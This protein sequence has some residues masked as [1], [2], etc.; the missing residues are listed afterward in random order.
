MLAVE[1]HVPSR[2]RARLVARPRTG[3][4]AAEHPL[5]DAPKETER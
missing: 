5:T 3:S 1:R 2:L 4:T